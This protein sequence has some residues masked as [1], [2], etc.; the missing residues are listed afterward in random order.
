M[1]E[2]FIGQKGF[3]LDRLATLCR[4]AECGGI[5]AAARQGLPAS[6]KTTLQH[7]QSQYS[8]QIAELEGFLGGE[9][10]MA[11]LDRSTK[12]FRLSPEGAELARLARNFLVGLDDFL[13]EKREGSPRLVIGAGERLIQWLIMPEMLPKLRAKFPG[14]TS[15]FLNRQTQDIVKG[16]QDGTLDFG[17]LRRGL[18]NANEFE[19]AGSWVETYHFFL[20][21]RLRPKLPAP[22]TVLNLGRYPLAVLEGGGETR[23]AIE[24]LFE[25]AG[26]KPNIQ[27]ECSS[28]TQVAQAVEMGYAAFLPHLAKG[29]MSADIQAHR[30]AGLE[31]LDVEQT[32]AWSKERALYRPVLRKI[33][34]ALAAV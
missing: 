5:M 16:L 15:L 2:Q 19:T 26:V 8:R 10:R 34:E 29:R 21:R 9:S 4:V 24:R 20:S 13:A 11:L 30:V 6:D 12:P 31:A 22:P 3:S 27:L 18:V 23:A 28:L 7:R 14:M 33:A 25:S 17:L 1:W 32:L